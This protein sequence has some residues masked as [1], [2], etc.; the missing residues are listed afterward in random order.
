MEERSNAMFPTKEEF[1][2]NLRRN[3]H[4]PTNQREWRATKRYLKR[5]GWR[6]AGW[7][8]LILCASPFLWVYG[9][10]KECFYELPKFYF[11]DIPRK[12]WRFFFKGG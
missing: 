11:Y 5:Y 8:L 3:F 7:W 9:V 6:I 1:K 10:L 2:K 4:I 12:L